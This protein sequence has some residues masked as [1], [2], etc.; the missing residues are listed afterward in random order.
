[1]QS[2]LN[3]SVCWF[4]IPPTVVVSDNLSLRSQFELGNAT[5]VNPEL[6][7]F[8]KMLYTEGHAGLINLN[9]TVS[10][11]PIHLLS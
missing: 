11:H 1:M 7:G 6:A 2:F 8:F 3:R 10:P 5:F 9:H 4:N